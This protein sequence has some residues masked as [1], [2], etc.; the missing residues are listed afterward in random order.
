MFNLVPIMYLAV[1]DPKPKNPDAP[2][3]VTVIDGAKLQC[4]SK[5]EST[6]CWQLCVQV[7][8]LL[9]VMLSSSFEKI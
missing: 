2:N 6:N 1:V 9:W 7:R 5:A 8:N 4:C 3:P